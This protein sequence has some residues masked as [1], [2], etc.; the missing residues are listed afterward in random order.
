MFDKRN[1]CIYYLKILERIRSF[2]FSC[3]SREF[4]IFLFFVFVFFCFWLFQVLNDDYEME[5]FVL[6]WLKNVFSD[7]VLIFEFFDELCIG[8]KD[9]G[10]VLVNY[11]L[12]QIFYFIVVDFK[13]YEDKGSCVWILVLVLMKKILVQLNQIIKLLI[14]WLDIVE[15]IYIKGK[16][17]K[18]FVKL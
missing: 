17:K 6:L 14:I 11:M 9:R 13:D 4:L 12:G 15:F 3:N 16:V 2:L 18:V 7:V 1:I 8:V 5:F 10:I